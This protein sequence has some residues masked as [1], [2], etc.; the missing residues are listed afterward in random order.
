MAQY[1]VDEYLLEEILEEN[2]SIRFSIGRRDKQYG[3][4]RATRRPRTDRRDPIRT[5][6]KEKEK[7]NNV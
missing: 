4:L 5:A 2:A 7:R 3:F 1:A 6:R